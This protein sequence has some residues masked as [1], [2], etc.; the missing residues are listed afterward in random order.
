ME[1]II[2]GKKL[3]MSQIFM[4]DGKVVPVTV[5]SSESQLSQ[6]LLNK[7]IVLIGKSKGKGFAGVIK[8][9]HF[10]GVGEETRG[11]SNKQRTAGS[12]GAQTPGRVLKGK[13]M[14]GR[15]GNRRVSVKGSKIISV[16]EA[17][18]KLMVSGPVPGAW[19]ADVLVKIL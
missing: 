17:N 16:D 6:D 10:A 11:Q 15:M 8:I 19:K 2:R 5:I 3:N 13:K 7:K 9:W 14:A 4:D 12:I 1:N 18:K